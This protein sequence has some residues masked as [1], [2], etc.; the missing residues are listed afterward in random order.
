MTDPTTPQPAESIDPV[1]PTDPT[2]EQTDERDGLGLRILT[3]V[4]AIVFGLLYAYVLFEAIGNLFNLPSFYHSLGIGPVPWWILL[5]GVAVPVVVFAMAFVLGRRRPVFARVL[6]FAVGLGVTN[7]LY[8]SLIAAE[9]A[10]R[11]VTG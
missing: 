2:P 10:L 8:L 11:P 6:L 4:I 1:A 7:A 3:G 9:S 5:C